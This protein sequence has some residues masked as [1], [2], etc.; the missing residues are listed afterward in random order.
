MN[1]LVSS[2]SRDF[3]G[4]ES[5]FLT[6]CQR[7]DKSKVHIDFICSDSSAAR[8][9][10][11]I[12]EGAKIYHIPRPG[13]HLLKYKAAFQE[14]LKN[15][16]YQILHVNMTRF[17]FPLEILLAKNCGLKVVLHSHSTQIYKS[18]S[19]KTDMVRRIQQVLFRPIALRNSDLNIACCQKAGEYL[20]HDH[21]YQI[22]YNGIDT[23]RFSFDPNERAR[24]REEF[25]IDSQ[26]KVIGH[27]GRF[28]DEKNH[29]FLL[30]AFKSVIEKDPSCRLLLVGS[31]DY[32]DRIKQLAQQLGLEHAVVFAGIRK[33]VP[34]LLS[35]M[36]LFMFPSIHEAFPMT[37]IEAQTNGLRCIV[38]DCVTKEI[39]VCNS[40]SY[41]SLLSGEREWADRIL[42]QFDILSCS[43]RKS[44]MIK[45]FDIA[46]M[47]DKLLKYY[48]E[49]R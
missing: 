28:S 36:D 30:R 15:G 39:D 11:F 32:F 29:P 1:I 19:A 24:I 49:L 48:I 4:V 7:C 10:D 3:G 18:N 16:N 45:E 44:I 22:V 12:K 20:F 21:P 13:K 38:S 43:N 2:L 41:V 17:T 5:L 26:Q 23:A 40:I 33:D 6:I 34:S 9:D 8:E 31:G 25:G 42:E 46:T 47:I 27:I 37:L 35:A 14:I